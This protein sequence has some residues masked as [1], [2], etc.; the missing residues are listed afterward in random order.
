M[1]ISRQGAVAK[2]M[3][4]LGLIAL[5]GCAETEGLMRS[6]PAEVTVEFDFDER[7][8]PN[9]PLPNDIATRPDPSAR[10]GLRVNASMIAPTGME[11]RTRTLIDGLDGWGVFQPLTIPF[12]GELDVESILAGHR[13]EDYDTSNDVIYLINIDRDSHEFGRIHHLDLGN[14]SYPIILERG[15]KYGSNDP[16][17]WT[18]SLLYD[19]ENE[20][21]DGDG[22]LDPGEDENGN[23]VLDPGEDRNGDGLLDPP[24]DSDAD[25]IL[26]KAN[27]L[28][29]H[30]PARDDL[31]GRADALMSFYEGETNTIIAAPLMP[32]QEETTYAAV[33]TR[34]LLDVDGEPVGSPFPYINHVAQSEKLAPLFEVLPPG[35]EREDIAFAFAYTTESV[36]SDWIAT[37]EGLYGYGPQAHLAKEF[38]AEIERLFPLKDL[39]P[40]SRFAGRK[41][42]YVIY[43]DDWR[44]Q[45]NIL[46]LGFFEGG[47]TTSEQFKGIVDGHDY[48][49]LH[50][51]GTYMS[52]QLFERFDEEGKRLPLDEQS[53]PTTLDTV[54][55]DAREEEIPFWI[56]LPRK[57][58]SV[59]G[60]GQMAP[61]V[62]L[63]HGYTSNRATELMGFSGF[64]SMFGVAVISTDNVSHGVPVGP[65]EVAMFDPILKEADLRPALDAILFS[66]AEDLNGD[67][68][69][70]SGVDFWTAY[71]FHTRD[72]MRQSAIDYMQLIRIVRTWDGVKRWD[73]D[74]NG[75]GQG[76][77]AGD[78]DGDGAVDIGKDSPIFVMGG[79]LGGIMATT[80]GSLEPEVE[81]IIPIAGG[82][83]LMDVGARSAQG[84]VPEAV[85][86]RVMGPLFLATLRDDGVTEL[87]TE[88]VELNRMPKIPLG[89]LNPCP[90]GVAPPCDGQENADLRV[91][92]WDTFVGVNLD[93]GEVDC[94]YMVPDENPD[95]GIAAT[96]RL[97]IPAD[98]PPE[99]APASGDRIEL[100]FYHGPALV[101]G[102][103]EC[104]VREGLE[105]F[106]IVNRFETPMN[107]DGTPMLF[108]GQPI[109]GGELR[110]FAEGLGLERATPS[111]RRFT[112]LAQLVIDPTDPAV[113]SRHLAQQPFDYPDKG[114]RTG[115][116]FLIVTTLGDMNVP[117]NSGVTVARAAGIVDFLQPDSRYG[118]PV[119]QVLIDLGVTEAVNTLR[120]WPYPE[121]PANETQRNLL[122]LDASLG[123]MIDVE[124][125]AE[126]NDLWGENVPRL[127]PPLRLYRED[128]DVYGNPLDGPSG[129]IFPY[130]I[131]QGQHGFALPGEMTDNAIKLCKEKN[132]SQAPQ[133]APEQI[134]GEV[135]DVG[136]YMFHAMGAYF[137]GGEVFGGRC[138]TKQSCNNL[139]PTPPPRD[140]SELQ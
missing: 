66:R 1:S 133:C 126:G 96:A 87:H 4:G 113:V 137:T 114:D 18:M 27:Y 44:A 48:I 36:T 21:R 75:D 86:M 73:Y 138:Y 47:D 91:K 28:P 117:A 54:P 41:N 116:R 33:V 32:L 49:D 106:Q 10:T 124:N 110:S 100:R 85:L 57:E 67:M 134:V 98:H 122:G 64:L 128:T 31:P 17:G 52:P 112:G 30:N 95:N 56:T 69:V 9:I 51:Q 79:S 58:V 5:P 38:P 14:G 34:R 94:G 76:D 127:D 23:G 12:T 74:L 39:S 37:R 99:G 92:P 125:F 65:A 136:W 101:T 77:L 71:M 90:E 3:V 25:G 11:R 132:G 70:D 35:L 7:P 42:P 43:Q 93:N 120:R 78:F 16:R 68:T 139:P 24:E 62:L 2:V 6:L 82:G 63:G 81:G 46:L 40:G 104:E 129:A 102:S 115:A 59:R 26:D 45:L 29:G 50:A 111:L 89:F 84:G 97:A 19:E 131:P 20:D 135:Y 130:A 108:L 53:W 80:L 88:A 60:Q 55:V 8:L 72:M 61:L 105:P 119:N 109:M 140:E 123:S 15:D 83:R 22:K 103:E 13:D 118:K 107:E 121:E